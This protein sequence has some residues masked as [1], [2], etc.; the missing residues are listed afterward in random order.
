MSEIIKSL[1]PIH[2]TVKYYKI[3]PKKKKKKVIF[4]QKK[5]QKIP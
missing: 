4:N 1:E 3:N 2:E 5:L